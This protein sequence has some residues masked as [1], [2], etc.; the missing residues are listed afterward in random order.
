MQWFP[1]EK[2]LRLESINDGSGGN[3]GGGGGSVSADALQEEMSCMR[4]TINEVSR[5]VYK[6]GQQMDKLLKAM[7]HLDGVHDVISTP[8][9]GTRSSISVSNRQRQ[10]SNTRT[11]SFSGQTPKSNAMPLGMSNA[12]VQ[13]LTGVTGS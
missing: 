1:R 6:Q 10:R 12:G 8:R 2:A 13:Q 7:S 9:V 11:G 5:A 3:D 4:D